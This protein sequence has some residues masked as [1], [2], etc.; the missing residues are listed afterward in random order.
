MP[1][2]VGE[3]ALELHRTHSELLEV[4]L[5]DE[6][7][8]AVQDLQGDVSYS[9]EG[10]MLRFGSLA[11]RNQASAQ[12]IFRGLTTSNDRAVFEAARALWRDEIGHQDLASG[13]LLGLVSLER[14]LL[15][16]GAAELSKG[17]KN[18]FDVS[19]MVEVALPHLAK[20]DVGSLIDFCKALHEP[21]KNDLATGRFFMR[22]KDALATQPNTALAVLTTLEQGVDEQ[23]SNLY[24]TSLRAIAA[25][26]INA[27]LAHVIAGISELK[28]VRCQ[29]CLWVLGLLA[30]SEKM[31]PEQDALAESA[32]APFLGSKDAKLH[33]QACVAV[34]DSLPTRS[35]CRVQWEAL[36]AKNDVTALRAL[37]STYYFSHEVL[38]KEGSFTEHLLSLIA[39]GPD[40]AAALSQVDHVL[41]TLLAKSNAY[42]D[43]VVRWLTDWVHHHGSGKFN[44]R[45]LGKIFDEVFAKLITKRTL[46]EKLVTSWL[47][48][49]GRALPAAASGLLSHLTVHRV[50]EIHFSRE[51]IDSLGDDDLLLL[52]RR[53]LGYV[54]SEDILI[55]MTLSLLDTNNAPARTF[56]LF[57]SVMINEVGYDYPTKALA[58]LRNVRAECQDE[59]LAAIFDQAVDEISGYQ[60]AFDNLPPVLELQPP[61]R[62]QRDFFRARQKQMQQGLEEARKDSVLRQVITEI[63]IKAGAGFFSYFENGYSTVSKMGTVETSFTLA[64]REV[65]DP[66]GNAMQRFMLQNVQRPPK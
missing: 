56:P 16:A 11:A 66:V 21:T 33:W 60:K 20:I 31:T 45:E 43:L 27:G 26:D 15:M 39:L 63:P 7:L 52:C 55:S 2:S 1:R 19:M 24:G 51:V 59:K 44:D 18:P 49:D 14:D 3:L 10:S 23:M 42:D 29:V 36:L 46:L 8:M 53:M 22:L 13:R 17:E 62:L 30:S 25:N 12:E 4:E 37:A 61:S 54:F 5:S 47:L 6:E 65:F 35:L 28:P 41:A 32:I 50:S 58:L 38:S 48:A 57:L 9:V 34:A 64:R 40:S